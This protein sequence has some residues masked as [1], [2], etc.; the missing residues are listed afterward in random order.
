M[1][2]VNRH[3]KSANR[4][5]VYLDGQLVG[6]AQNARMNDDYGPD[7]L[8]GI[9]DIHVIEHVPTIARHS[10]SV[11]QIALDT[12]TLRQMGVATQNGDDALRGLVFDFLVLDKDTGATLKKY[13]G[14]TYASGSVEVTKHQMVSANAEFMAIDTTGTAL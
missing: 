14:C 11:Q 7:P 2:T 9:G 12:G 6:A 4:V 8:S 13:V 5:L 1:P 3:A 10:V